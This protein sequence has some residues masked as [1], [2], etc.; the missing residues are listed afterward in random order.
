MRAG[1][2]TVGTLLLV[3]IIYF[4]RG[5]GRTGFYLALCCF[6]FGLVVADVGGWL[7]RYGLLLVHLVDWVW[8]QLSRIWH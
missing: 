2:I 8:Y 3:G 1:D 5:H 4:G 7:D 6:L